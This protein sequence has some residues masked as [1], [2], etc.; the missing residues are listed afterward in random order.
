M[1][2]KKGY[3]PRASAGYPSGPTMKKSSMK[4]KKMKRGHKRGKAY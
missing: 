1:P 2:R 4:S 3:K